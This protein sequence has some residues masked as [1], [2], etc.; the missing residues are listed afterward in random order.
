M[1][2]TVIDFGFGGTRIVV[3]QQV[4]RVIYTISENLVVYH[5]RGWWAHSPE[6][7][8]ELSPDAD[9]LWSIKSPLSPEATSSTPRTALSRPRSS[10][11]KPFL[12]S[13]VHK[14]SSMVGRSSSSSLPP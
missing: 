8:P 6:L 2:T 5:D 12:C 9:L 14:I 4:D 10:V 13:V 7:P 1:K 11:L 3:S